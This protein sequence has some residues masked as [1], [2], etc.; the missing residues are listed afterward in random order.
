MPE[1]EGRKAQEE[2]A[3]AIRKKIEELKRGDKTD[4][5]KRPKSPREFID[6]Q[7]PRPKPD[8]TSED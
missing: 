3:D 2:R 8:E 7:T 6:E 4:S 5:A 1:D